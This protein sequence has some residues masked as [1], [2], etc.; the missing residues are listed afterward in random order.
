MKIVFGFVLAVMTSGLYGQDLAE[1]CVETS[2]SNPALKKSDEQILRYA[3]YI[4][5]HPANPFD[6]TRNEAMAAVLLWM[7]STPDYTF[8]IDETIVPVIKKDEEILAIYMVAMTQYV[9]ENPHVAN[10]SDKVKLHAFTRLLIYCDNPE[11]NIKKSK[12]ITQ[13]IYTMRSG[14]LKEYLKI[15]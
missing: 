8:L 7:V 6:S 12:A 5:S 10:D 2:Y 13:A 11:N 4:M 3:N 14:W 9:L 15:S 1:F